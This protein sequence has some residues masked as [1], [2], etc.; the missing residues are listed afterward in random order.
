MTTQTITL[1]QLAAVTHVCWGDKITL[2]HKT[3]IKSAECRNW[4]IHTD[5]QTDHQSVY[6]C[7]LLYNVLVHGAAPALES[8]IRN[9]RH[10]CKYLIQSLRRHA[11]RHSRRA[12]V[13]TNKTRAVLN[14]MATR[15]WMRAICAPKFCHSQYDNEDVRFHSV[16]RWWV[17]LSHVHVV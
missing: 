15:S 7:P 14:C 13:K 12:V 4:G 10:V 17:I 8:T 5:R 9:W 2:S 16:L 1:E 3:I 6:W 11:Y